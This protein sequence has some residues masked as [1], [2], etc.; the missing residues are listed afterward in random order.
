MLLTTTLT[1]IALS[2]PFLT[3][4]A[5]TP[6][7]AR[8]DAYEPVAFTNDWPTQFCAGSTYEISYTGGS[9]TYNAWQWKS[10]PGLPDTHVSST[11]SSVLS[12]HADAM[13]SPTLSAMGRPTRL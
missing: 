3:S 2:L 7:A 12:R 4:S 11:G 5:A 8:Q 9:G 13:S 6:V 1:S 10:Y